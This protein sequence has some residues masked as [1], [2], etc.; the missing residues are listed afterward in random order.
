MR[1][2]TAWGG[3]ASTMSSRW[4][5]GVASAGAAMP[6]LCTVSKRRS[7]LSRASL[8][9]V[10][11]LG[12]KVWSR[13]RVM[14]LGPALAAVFDGPGQLG[15]VGEV[16]FR[17]EPAQLQ[18]GTDLAFH[19][20]EEFHHEVLAEED[21]GVAALL[22]GRGRGRLGGFGRHLAVDARARG[23]HAAAFA[24]GAAAARHGPPA[25]PCRPRALPGRPG[26]RPP[27]RPLGRPQGLAPRS[28]ATGP[29][30]PRAHRGSGF[31]PGPGR[32]GSGAGR[33]APRRRPR[34]PPPPGRRRTAMSRWTR[35][36][37]R[38]PGPPLSLRPRARNHGRAAM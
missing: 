20:A 14:G 5:G 33:R 38:A 32:P 34:R 36:A 22:S 6:S 2:S 37:S 31:R 28:S 29:P 19:A 8:Q 30:R 26:C 16:A 24:L 4:P 35:A 9:A 11:W 7:R 18:L 23:R 15:R 27:R 1:S 12:T 10:P 21:H 13:A 17:E 3:T 25:G